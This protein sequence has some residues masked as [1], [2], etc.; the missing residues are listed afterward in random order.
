MVLYKILFGLTDYSTLLNL[1]LLMGPFVVL[2]DVV[3]PYRILC[4]LKGYKVA[5]VLL[6]S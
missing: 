1:M 6:W 5:Q 2:Q 3:V 4:G